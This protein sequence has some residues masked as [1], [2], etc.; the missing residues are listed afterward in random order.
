MIQSTGKNSPSATDTVNTSLISHNL[1]VAPDSIAGD[2]TQTIA[3]TVIAS[4]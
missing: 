3:Y 4:F 1:N 2:Y